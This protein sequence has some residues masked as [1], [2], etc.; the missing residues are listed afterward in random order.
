MYAMLLML[1]ISLNVMILHELKVNGI[2]IDS[3]GI[4]LFGK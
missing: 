4:F 3:T 1:T 2:H